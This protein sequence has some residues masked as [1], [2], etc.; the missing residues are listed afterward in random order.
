MAS[1]GRS[2]NIVDLQQPGKRLRGGRF[3]RI[4]PGLKG[5]VTVADDPKHDDPTPPM[6]RD[7]CIPRTMRST[8]QLIP[9]QYI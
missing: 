5:P 7:L 8:A 1:G 6:P 2:V 3:V 4:F 9:R